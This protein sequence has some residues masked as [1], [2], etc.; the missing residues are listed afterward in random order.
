M[1][2]MIERRGKSSWRIRFDVGRDAEGKRRFQYITVRGKRADAEAKLSE[3]LA[4]VGR[5]EFVKPA[6]V[7]VAEW[8]NQRL[9]AWVAAKD[10]GGTTEQGYR[11]AVDC[12]ILPH[13]GTRTIQSLKP[14][15]IDRWH[16]ALRADNLSA[17]TIGSAHRVLGKALREGAKFG[18]VVRNVC[19]SPAGGQSAPRVVRQEMQILTEPEMASVLE[20]LTNRHE[21][22]GNRGRPFQLGRTLY[23]KVVI[24]LFT[25]MRRG[26]I[27]ALRWGHMDLEAGVIKVREALEETK[28]YGLRVKA[29]KTGAGRRDITLPDIVVEALAEHRRAQLEVRMWLALGRLTDDALVFPALDGNYQ[30][31][32]NLSGDWREFRLAVDAPE[33]GFHAL[34]HTH[35]SMLIAANV[36]IVEISKRLG[37]ADPAI[38]LKIYAHLFRSDD[39]KS[40]AAINATLTRLG[41][42]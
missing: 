10:I 37:H 24:A 7:T 21:R 40:A 11:R 13:L 20:K 35:A 16:T 9:D 15:C 14:L 3:M 26:E 22:R 2:G 41:K 1:R 39:S 32:N 36:D 8:V 27:M 38:T 28:K 4:A 29:T 34:R 31:P 18:M 25:G 5:G 23:P 30:S 19:S 33:V 6:K 42:R 12:Y 17:R